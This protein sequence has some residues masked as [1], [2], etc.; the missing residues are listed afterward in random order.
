MSPRRTP[1][2]RPPG[3]ALESHARAARAGR[4]G[5]REFLALA[6]AMGASTAAAFAML[7]L[8]APGARARPGRMGG[9][10]RCQMEVKR[11]RDPRAFDWSEMGNVARGLVEPLALY[12]L[13]F[14]FE[15]WLLE[16]WEV[17]ADAQ[18]YTLRLRRG[19]SWSNGDAFTAEDVVFNLER[20]CDRAAEGNSMAARMT[21]LIDENTGRAAEGAIE[22]LDD[23]TVRLNLKRSDITLIPSMTDYP[24]L[25]VHRDFEATGADLTANPVGTGPYMIEEVEVGARASLVRRGEWWGGEVGPDRI[26][27]LDYGTDPADFVA[28]FE[29]DAID[30]V[31]QTTADFVEIFDGLGLAREETVTANTVVARTNV[32]AEIDGRRPY[33]EARARRALQLAVDNALVLLIGYGGRGRKADDHHVGPMHPEH[34]P[35]PEAPYD[36]A[37]A[38]ALLEEAGMADFEHELIS[39]DDDW[40]RN[41][42]DAIAAQ[43]RDAGIAVKR[44]ILPG[45]V[46]WAGWKSYPFSVTDWNMRPLGVQ[47][48]A[49]AYRSGA[50]WNETGWS[51]PEFDASLEEAM[52]IADAGARRARMERVERLL[53]EAGVIIQP[54]WRAIFRHHRERVRGVEMHQSFEHHHHLWWLEA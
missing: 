15:P 51:S 48:L 16:G 1:P 11:V 14:G 45:E 42:A 26:E 43:L 12:T 19:V 34:F 35:L 28:A 47:V 6:T 23:H 54:Y 36:P 17:S 33:A 9:T 7:G 30:M 49:L 21:A 18:V 20:W 38:R 27:Y 41:T 2:P 5:R 22:R 40:R 24:A 3:P 4:L 50:A 46:F 25:I 37:R 29:A 31:H 53:Q 13:D 44:T 32:G 52:A 10:L 39:I 8:P